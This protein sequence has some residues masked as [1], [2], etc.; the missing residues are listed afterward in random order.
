MIILIGGTKGGTGKSTICTNLVVKRSSIGKNTLLIDGDEQRTTSKWVDHRER[1]KIPTE[2]TTVQYYG[3]SMRE[4][5]SKLRRKYDEIFIDCGGK[6]SHSQRAALTVCDVLVAP[7]APKSFDVWSTC[8]L[9]PLVSEA[10][11]YNPNLKVVIVINQADHFG[12]D[13]A[14]AME[15]LSQEKNVTC[16]TQVIKRRKAFSNASA[17]GLG[18]FELE[19]KDHKAIYE[20]QQVC[21]AIFDT[22]II[23]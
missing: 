12:K 15:I 22:K 11:I 19:P 17:Q 13:N 16:L 5:I 8:E 20:M 2:W 6:D 3:A 18:I 9:I 4:Q 14:A 21:D 23:L 10:R 1:K 7:F